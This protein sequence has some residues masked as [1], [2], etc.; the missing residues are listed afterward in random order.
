[1]LSGGFHKKE[2]G[3]VRVGEVA[4]EARP[5]LA[6]HGTEGSQNWA[7]ARRV[8]QPSRW[9]DGPALGFAAPLGGVRAA[10]GAF[11]SSSVLIIKSTRG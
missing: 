4:M 3:G 1:M 10:D 2:V 11:P 8:R 6:D 9:R 5:S 7:L